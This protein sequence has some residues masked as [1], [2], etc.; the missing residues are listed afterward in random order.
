MATEI[1][2][3]IAEYQQRF[4]ISQDEAITRLRT[5][6]QELKAPSP[7]VRPPRRPP[8]PTE[9]I[10]RVAEVILPPLPG[11]LPGS[12]TYANIGPGGAET[13]KGW[14]PPG[15]RPTGFHRGYWTGEA[16]EVLTPCTGRGSR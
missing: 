5:D 12:T 14:R 7:V 1:Q 13:P 15:I 9:V 4:G 8:A 2:D 6:L 11:K 10:D 16:G 3:L